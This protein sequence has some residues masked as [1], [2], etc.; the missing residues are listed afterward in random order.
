MSTPHKPEP[1]T[2]SW[3]AWAHQQIRAHAWSGT[4]AHVLETLARFCDPH[5]HIIASQD[6]LAT[7]AHCTTRSIARALKTYKETRLIE[8]RT[9]Y[10]TRAGNH[11]K[12]RTASLIILKGNPEATH[13]PTTTPKP[14]PTLHPLPH[15]YIET[16]DDAET[17]KVAVIT[18]ASN[19][20]RHAESFVAALHA[21]AAKLFATQAQTLHLASGES[22]RNAVDEIVELAF[23]LIT[24]KLHALATMAYPLAYVRRALDHEAAKMACQ[25][26][27]HAGIPIDDEANAELIESGHLATTSV[28]YPPLGD[29]HPLLWPVVAR[30]QAAGAHECDIWAV[31]TRIIAICADSDTARAAKHAANDE[32][33]AELGLTATQAQ[34]WRRHMREIF[35]HTGELSQRKINQLAESLPQQ[36]LPLSA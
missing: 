26:S 30:I 25:L 24:A 27:E 36:S 1:L 33:L 21:G 10:N 7:R 20:T 29:L 32:R 16:I 14:R 4:R 12:A 11:R 8:V 6:W 3:P 17:F 31:I 5:G 15:T 2:G 35:T 22:H 13:A 19:P 23:S 28:T 9:L 18:Y 34:M